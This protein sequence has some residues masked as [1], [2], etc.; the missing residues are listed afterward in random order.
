MNKRNVYRGLLRINEERDNLQD[1]T[2][3]GKIMLKRILKIEWERVN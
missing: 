3:D 1:L 2:I